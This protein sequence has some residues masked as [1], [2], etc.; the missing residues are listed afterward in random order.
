MDKSWLHL[1]VASSEAS[2]DEMMS[3]RVDASNY[4]DFQSGH[5]H[6]NRRVKPR[7]INIYMTAT[8]ATGVIIDPITSQHQS[9][10]PPHT[11]ATAAHPAVVVVSWQRLMIS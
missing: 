9:P 8:P 10:G 4:S 2:H 11:V 3:Y 6:S 5:K 7:P 1:R